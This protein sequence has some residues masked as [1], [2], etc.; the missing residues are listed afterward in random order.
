VIIIDALDECKDDEFDSAILSFLGRLVSEIPKVK[1]FLTGRPDPRIQRGFRLPL[2]AQAADVFVLHDVKS[3]LI[4]DDIRLYLER[5]LQEIEG[6]RGVWPTEKQLDLLCKRAGGLFVYA[7]ATVKFKAIAPG[8]GSIF[9]PS[10]TITVLT[11]E[12]QS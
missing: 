3:N 10:H 11:K 8:N 5:S 6:H 7:V 12:K 1:F 9:C 4:D 2:L